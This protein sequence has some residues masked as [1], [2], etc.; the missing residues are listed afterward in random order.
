MPEWDGRAERPVSV[1]CNVLYDWHVTVLAWRGRSRP[2]RRRTRAGSRARTTATAPR[3]RGTRC[4]CATH[5]RY[6]P[7]LTN[8]ASCTS[9]ADADPPAPVASAARTLFC[10]FTFDSVAPR[11]MICTRTACYGVFGLTDC[12][13]VTL[14]NSPVSD[15]I[16][17]KQKHSPLSMLCL[18]K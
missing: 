12:A 4:P 6:R 16:S 14:W 17:L 9:G 2:G 10:S 15:S 3:T 7:A 13:F 11:S 1:A 8:T 5:D 18:C